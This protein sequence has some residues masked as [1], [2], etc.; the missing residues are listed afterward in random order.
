MIEKEP[1]FIVF[2]MYIYI[3]QSILF[4]DPE[5]VIEIGRI[6][7]GIEIGIGMLIEMAIANETGAERDQGS[8]MQHIHI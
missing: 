3:H 8:Q 5:I 7:T 6:G 2:S 4:R 1:E